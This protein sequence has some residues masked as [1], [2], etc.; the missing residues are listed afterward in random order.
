M[1]DKH[2]RRYIRSGASR[3]A[4]SPHRHSPQERAVA[5]ESLV[6]SQNGAVSG[7][8]LEELWSTKIRHCDMI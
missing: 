4:A 3:M 6:R 7:V 8:W 1:S 2:G 5:F